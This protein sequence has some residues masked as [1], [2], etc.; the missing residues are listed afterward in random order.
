M[1]HA[2]LLSVHVAA[3]TV[4]LVLG[5]LALAVP[6]RAGWH[7]RLGVSYQ[8]AVAAMTSSALGLTALAPGR[9]WWLG[10]IAAATETAALAG[11]RVKRRHA[12][13]W[14]GKHVRLMCGSYLSFITAA[15][16]VNWGSPLA[17]VLPTLIGVPLIN[18]A[19]G[20]AAR[21]RAAAGQPARTRIAT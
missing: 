14:L 7:S 10:V 21:S 15:L 19:V 11:W 12:P 3:G 2:V 6:K 18:R 17:W 1:L 20:R 5:L 13:G 9:L 8:A 16:V 4:G